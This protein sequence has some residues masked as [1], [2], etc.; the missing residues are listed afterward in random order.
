MLNIRT[1][2]VALAFGLTALGVGALLGGCV[3]QDYTGKSYAPT[4]RVDVFYSEADVG[5]PFEVMGTDRAE[6]GSGMKSDRIVQEMVKEAQKQGADGIIV[7]DVAMQRTGSS[8]NAYGD[9]NQYT[10]ETDIQERV[11]TAR[12]IKYRPA[13][14]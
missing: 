2:V 5:R 7:D 14:E 8:S 12:F 9:D 13:A 3:N 4:Q 1:A 11:V 10:Y 6:A